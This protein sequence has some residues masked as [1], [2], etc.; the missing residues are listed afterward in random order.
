[1]SAAHVSPKPTDRRHFQ[2]KDQGDTRKL[3]GCTDPTTGKGLKHS[4]TRSPPSVMT[5]S[6]SSLEEKGL[7]PTNEGVNVLDSEP[8]NDEYEQYLELEQRMTGAP[9][10]K[11]MRKLDFRLLPSL[12]LLYLLASLDKANAGNAKLFGF[13]E[14]VGMTSN[15]FN[16]ALTVLFFT[17]GLFEPI[18]NVMLRRVGPK[19]WFPIAVTTWGLITTLT[20]VVKS[21]GGFIGIRLALGAA[22]ATIYPGDTSC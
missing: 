9:H 12:S 16:L 13:L 11:L 15:Q 7:T 20:C 2:D 1:M 22:E 19:I 14:D 5:S 6:Q 3:N 17:Y 18:C 21:Y 4:V 10:R 8:Q